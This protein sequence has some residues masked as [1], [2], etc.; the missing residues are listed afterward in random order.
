MKIVIKNLCNNRDDDDDDEDEA[1][2]GTAS[3]TSFFTPKYDSNDRQK[4]QFFKE[5][6]LE[7]VEMF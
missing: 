5:R 7:P 4:H 3:I 2:K 1:A 6:Q